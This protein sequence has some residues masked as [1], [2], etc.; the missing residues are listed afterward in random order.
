MLCGR[1]GGPQIARDAP[2]ARARPSSFQMPHASSNHW[3]I[4]STSPEP[5]TVPAWATWGSRWW[6]SGA[7]GLES[8]HDR[9]HILTGTL[10]CRV[11][12]AAEV[13]VYPRT[14]VPTCERGAV[15]VAP[16]RAALSEEMPSKMSIR[17]TLIAALRRPSTASGNNQHLSLMNLT[18]D[19]GSVTCMTPVGPFGLGRHVHTSTSIVRINDPHAF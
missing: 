8:H 10:S 6:C 7:W 19:W 4:P 17:S 15:H 18:K 5:T 9:P 12:A 3:S 1:A 2:C 14:T 13:R 11:L 16:Q